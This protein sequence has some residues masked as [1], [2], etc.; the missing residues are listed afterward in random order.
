[1]C[2][3]IRGM[4]KNKIM[5]AFRN[6]KLA[7]YKIFLIIIFKYKNLIDELKLSELKIRRP[8]L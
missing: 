5:N 1:M 2:T 3:I 4:F 6:L 7:L 8:I